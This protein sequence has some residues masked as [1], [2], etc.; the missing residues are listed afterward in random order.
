MSEEVEAEKNDR[1][2][3]VLC[4]RR[5]SLPGDDVCLTCWAETHGEDYERPSRRVHDGE[6][7]R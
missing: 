7:E 3:C 2:T 1:V 4:E 5:D 6:E